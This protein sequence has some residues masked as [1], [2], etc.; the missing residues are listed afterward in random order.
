MRRNEVKKGNTLLKDFTYKDGAAIY[1]FAVLV[2]LGLQLLLGMFVA[3]TKKTE[4][5]E[6]DWVNMLVSILLQAAFL[7]TIIVYCLKQRTRPDFGIKLTHPANYALSALTAIVALVGFYFV[8]LA[9][10]LLLQT[11]GY[12]STDPFVFET[13][14]AKVLGVIG[15]CVAAPICEELIF[16]GALLSGLKKNFKEPVAILLSGLTFSLMHM[17]PEQTVYQFLLGCA[18]AYLVI[19]TGSLIVGMIGHC[20]SNLIAMLMA[21]ITPFGEA[22]DS[23]IE[24]VYNIPWL[25]ALMTV[26]LAVAG[27]VA[28]FFIGKLMGKL[29]GRKAET[30]FTSV[31]PEIPESQEPEGGETPAPAKPILKSTFGGK[32]FLIIG[33]SVCAVMW[34]IMLVVGLIPP[35]LLPEV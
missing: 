4:I 17:N 21:L 12:S 22:M 16:R 28:I 27:A 18:L 1:A 32:T 19:K 25:F 30:N 9:F 24:A 7:T 14:A 29:S 33:I 15:T 34:V 5:L 31:P 3:A 13:T 35:D 26:A 20:V 8:A 10:D 6:I 11:M 23:A 2:D